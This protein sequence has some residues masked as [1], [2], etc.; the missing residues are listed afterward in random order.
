MPNIKSIRCWKCYDSDLKKHDERST[1][2][3]YTD[4]YSL[5]LF[6]PRCRKI[7]LKSMLVI[8]N[9]DLGNEIPIQNLSPPKGE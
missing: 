3:A 8:S 2:H 7:R 6:C 4:G 1:L 5:F 9:R